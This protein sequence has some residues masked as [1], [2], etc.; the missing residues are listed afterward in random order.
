MRSASALRFSKGCSSLNLDRILVVVI[1]LG[2]QWSGAVKSAVVG[3]GCGG[4]YMEDGGL[5]VRGDILRESGARKAAQLMRIT[6]AKTRNTVKNPVHAPRFTEPP[7]LI[8]L[9]SCLAALSLA[10]NAQTR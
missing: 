4:G 2:W 10:T 7:L 5:A 8:R 1:V 3:G 6:A 9:L